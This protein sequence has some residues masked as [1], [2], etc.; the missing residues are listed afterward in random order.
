MNEKGVDYPAFAKE[1]ASGVQNKL[2]SH[3]R[4]M[5][6]FLKKLWQ[7]CGH[8]GLP[9]FIGVDFFEKHFQQLK[10]KEKG[11]RL[12]LIIPLILKNSARKCFT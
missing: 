4:S 9:F 3:Y 12:A 1:R 11:G 10:I 8:P 2:I 5:T 6:L 7:A